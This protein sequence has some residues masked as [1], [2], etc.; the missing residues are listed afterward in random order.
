MQPKHWTAFIF[1]GGIWSASFLWIKIAL[2]E[3]GP[4]TLVAWRV[5]FGLVVCRRSGLLPAQ[6][7]ATRL[8]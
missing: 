1:L 4:N 8:G 2:D 3:I 6:S 5:L 7:L